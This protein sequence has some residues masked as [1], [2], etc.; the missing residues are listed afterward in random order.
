MIAAFLRAMRGQPAGATPVGD[1][2]E[3]S[4]AF[5]RGLALGAFVGAALAGSTLWRRFRA[6][7]R[8]AGNGSDSKTREVLR[9]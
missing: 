6:R 7:S 2:D 9:D 8:E 4:P 1:Q 3:D 5:V